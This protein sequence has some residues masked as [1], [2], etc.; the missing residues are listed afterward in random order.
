MRLSQSQTTEADAAELTDDE[1]L[2]SS[3]FQKWFMQEGAWWCASFVF[4]MLIMVLLMLFGNKALRT[5]MD[6]APKFD[7]AQE[8]QDKSPIPPDK[9]EIFRLND[10]TPVDPGELSTESLTQTTAP[11][12]EATGGDGMAVADGGSRQAGGSVLGGLG[13]FDVK[14]IGPGGASRGGTGYGGDARGRGIGGGGGT[15]QGFG[16]RGSGKGKLVG[17]F[18]GTKAT[19]RSVGAALSWIARHQNTQ[20]GSWSI[21]DFAQRCKGGEEGTCGGPGIKSS[22]TAA[23]AMALLPF[24]ASGQTHESRGP[25]K[26]TIYSGLWWLLSAQ[27]PDGDLRSGD[28]TFYAHGLSSICLCEAYGLT[29]DKELGKRAQLAIDFLLKTQNSSDGGWRYKIGQAGDT[30]VVGWQL[31]AMKSAQMAGLKVDHAAFEGVKKFLSFVAT[32]EHKGLYG[33]T[34]EAPSAK[35]STTAVGMLCQQY[36]GMKRDDPAMLEGTQLLLKNMPDNKRRDIYRWYYATQ[37]L[38]NMPGTDWDNWN[39]LMRRVLIETQIRDG[40]ATG[41]WDPAIPVKDPWGEAGGRLYM[42][43][44]ATLTLEVYYRYLPLYKLDTESPVAVGGGGGRPNFDEDEAKP[45]AEKPAAEKPAAEKPAAKKDAKPAAKAGGKTA[46]KTDDKSKA[47]PKPDA[48]T[49]PTDKAKSEDK[50]KEKPATE[51]K[52]GA[53][54]AEKPKTTTKTKSTDKTKAATDKAKAKP[55]DK[56]K[57]DDKN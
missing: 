10:K 30:S 57:P 52:E 25:Y 38:H 22:D 39:R 32:G 20:N 28:G 44:L 47:K 14:G 48:E 21:G 3:D 53:K 29:G 7:A 37:V 26:A 9:I 16:N 33:Y 56:P 11:E 5:A 49:K 36:M 24:L 50:S 8:D 40:C 35:P 23:T 46:A 45:A 2:Q 18:G 6:D 17:G 19:E 27:K 12:V 54:S 13:G 15:G 4:H 1:V 51:T 34:A 43:S 41:S 42:T 55:A 31:M